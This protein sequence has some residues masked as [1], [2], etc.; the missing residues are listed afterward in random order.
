LGSADN[1]VL[2]VPERP[3]NNATSLPGPTLAEQ[4]IGITL[5]A[6]R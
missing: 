3:K 2:P 1:V 5:S 6:G 4:C